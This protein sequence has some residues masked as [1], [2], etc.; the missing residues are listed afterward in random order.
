MFTKD[1]VCDC[2][3]YYII[4]CCSFGTVTQYPVPSLSL[5]KRGN[6]GEKNKRPVLLNS[7]YFKFHSHDPQLR[8]IGRVL[9][10]RLLSYPTTLQTVKPQEKTFLTCT[11]HVNAYTYR[12]VSCFSASDFS[13]QSTSLHLIPHG[14]T[15]VTGEKMDYTVQHRLTQR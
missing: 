13:K 6:V 2:N 12:T 3:V 7:F 11:L 14:L 8:A 4:N 10:L 15:R 9:P 1:C 5:V